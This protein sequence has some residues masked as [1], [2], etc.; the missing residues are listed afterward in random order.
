MKK[1]ILVAP[2]NW[3]IGHA[4]RCIPII[5][6]L[7][8]HN[9]E[10]V[11]A[12]DNEALHLLKKEF[13]N[14]EYVE[15][16]SYQVT[17]SKTK[18]KFKSHL[19]KQL[20]KIYKALKAE[21]KATQQIIETY[22]IDGIISD[23]RLGVYS[24]AVKSVFI[25]HQLN[26]LTGSTTFISTKLHAFFMM[27]FNECWIP[28]FETE[29]NLSGKLSHPST[30]KTKITTKYIG[31]LS[32]FELQEEQTIYAVLI[33]LSGP[34]PQRG[35]LEEKLR[36]EFKNYD[37]PVLLVKGKIEATQT[38]VT[39][40]NLTEVNFLTS[41]HLEKTINQSDLIIA[42][43]GYTT[44]MDLAKL[45]KNAFLIPT[46]GQSEQEYLAQN[47]Q[48]QGIAPFCEQD[49]FSLK[50]LEKSGNYTGFGNFKFKD[51]LNTNLFRCFI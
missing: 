50:Q 43:S 38:T 35:L 30:L 34:E 22:N 41:K 37:K 2:L 18:S 10:V 25:T 1:R 5:N 29:P 23:N 32:R 15:L 39:N 31:P 7:I 16:P 20:P 33:L 45:N 36:D 17:Y 14:L 8:S 27:K 26:V 44:I 28:D 9:F 47:M 4:C 42:R 12:S 24:K 21:H 46:P 19:L 6:A 11:I 51:N 49:Q 3:G 40:G 13:P 48:E